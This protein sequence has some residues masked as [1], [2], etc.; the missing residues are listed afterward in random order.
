MPPW[1][2]QLET[3]CLA[4]STLVGGL[5]A[6]RESPSYLTSPTWLLSFAYRRPLWILDER[7]SETLEF[8]GSSR[9]ERVRICVENQIHRVHA[10]L[11]THG[12]RSFIDRKARWDHG[13]KFV[14]ILF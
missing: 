12:L 11:L 4:D 7:E 10:A 5:S 14:A 13:S 9:W 8:G 3:R 1:I 2:W 6:R